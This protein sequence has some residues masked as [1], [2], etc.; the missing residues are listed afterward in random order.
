MTDTGTPTVASPLET[1]GGTAALRAEDERERAGPERGRE[2]RRRRGERAV[3]DP[4]GHLGAVDVHDQWIGRRSALGREDGGDRRGVERV[5]REAID[6]FGRDGDQATVAQGP[7]GL[8][9]H[10]GIGRVR[11]AGQDGCGH[12]NRSILRPWWGSRFP[13]RVE[14]TPV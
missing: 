11:G 13:A 6:R 5:G 3:D 7:A 12:R 4:G 8:L 1:T 10:R 14:I 9:D 2:D